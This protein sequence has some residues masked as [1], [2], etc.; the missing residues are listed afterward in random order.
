MGHLHDVKGAYA[1][2]IDR[3]DKTQSGMPKTPETFAIL[4]HL[5]TRE[6][7]E[8]GS[9]M[10]L[11][12]RRIGTISRRTGI[13]RPE[14]EKK[15]DAMAEKGLIFDFCHPEQGKYYMLAPPIVGFFEMSMMRVR[16]DIDQKEV[17]RL[18]SLYIYDRDEFMAEAMRGRTPVGRAL[19]YESAMD[20]AVTS[21]VMRYERASELIAEAN[22]LGVAL[23]YCRHKKSHLGEACDAP[24]DVCLSLGKAAE[25]SIRHGHARPVDKAEAL[26]KMA[27]SRELGLVHITDNVKDEPAYLC[28]CCG[29]CCGQLSAINR[30]G[31]GHAVATSNFIAEIN[32]ENCTGCGKCVQRCPV[33]AISLRATAPQVRAKTKR[34]MVAWVDEDI[35]LG[36]GVCH[37]TCKTK[38]LAIRSRDKRVLT[39]QNTLERVVSMSLGRGHLH[40]MLFDEQ[41]GPTAAF[42]NNLTGALENMSLT[43]RLVL[44]ETLKSRFVTFLVNQAT[45]GKKQKATYQIE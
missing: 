15:L 36:C 42:L 29:C 37:P 18:L 1:E 34:K 6:E 4:R 17:A 44:N 38:A 41:D 16:H 40:D 24:Q 3:I 13:G 11:T 20:A 25:Y 35:C 19:M 5:F 9:K 45:R 32:S 8:I 31:I 39:P 12:P 22:L 2:L 26:E 7:A 27:I 43:K 14:L 23:C 10:P 33:Q 21:D 28:N 30:H